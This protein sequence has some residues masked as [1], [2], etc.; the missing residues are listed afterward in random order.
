MAFS[1]CSALQQWQHRVCGRVSILPE[2]TPL[3]RTSF[4]QGALK[5]TRGQID[6]GPG[7]YDVLP[8]QHSKGCSSYLFCMRILLSSG[9]F[10]MYY[11]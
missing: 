1:I 11:F 6:S 7:Q 4:F 10:M 9:V 3:K 2:V 8:A 5:R